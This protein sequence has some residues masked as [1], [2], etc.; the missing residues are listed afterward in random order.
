MSQGH[1]RFPGTLSLNQTTLQ[2]IV[3]DITDAVY[4]VG[5]RQILL[6]NGHQWNEGA[7]LSI[8]EEL[9]AKYDDL[10]VRAVPYWG[11]GN[12]DAYAGLP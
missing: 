7:L 2:A 10:Q 9:R 6:L 5:I 4:R 3:A 1:G 8:R 12:T 11:F